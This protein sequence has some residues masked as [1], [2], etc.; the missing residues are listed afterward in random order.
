MKWLDTGAWLLCCAAIYW[1]GY[2]RGRL[3]E[4]HWWLERKRQGGGE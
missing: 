1:A 4:Q 3:V 2:Q